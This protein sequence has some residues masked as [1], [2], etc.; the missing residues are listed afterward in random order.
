[1]KWRRRERRSGENARGRSETAR[2][3][4]AAVIAGEQKEKMSL[5]EEDRPLR[6][7]LGEKT[8]TD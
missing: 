3:V 7:S 5:G 2:R 1:M 6:R 4:R 8:K